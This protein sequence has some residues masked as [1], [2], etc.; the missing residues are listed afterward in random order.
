MRWSACQTGMMIQLKGSSEPRNISN[1]GVIW[2]TQAETAIRSDQSQGSFAHSLLNMHNTS[3]NRWIN[4][5][6]TIVQTHM[7][8]DSLA[9]RLGQTHIVTDVEYLEHSHAHSCM[10]IHRFFFYIIFF[11][12]CGVF[13]HLTL[14]VLLS[15]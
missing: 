2:V 5:H 4:A 1:Q 10:Q 8:S 12:F 14:L 9:G 3:T 13:P 11:L 15:R 7:P 6:G